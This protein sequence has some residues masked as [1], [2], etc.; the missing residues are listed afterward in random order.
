MASANPTPSEYIVHHLGH[1]ATSKQT[2]I[3]DFSVLNIDTLFW[4][5]MMGALTLFLLH[6]AATVSYTHL[7][8]PTICS[9]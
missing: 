1:L 5:I 2:A 4:S 6:R 9:V 8:L 3:V 7:T